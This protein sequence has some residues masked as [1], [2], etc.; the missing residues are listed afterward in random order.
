MIGVEGARSLSEAFK[1]N[2]TLTALNLAGV[3]QDDKSKHGR[4][5]TSND[6][7]ENWISVEGAKALSEALKVN[8]ALTTLDLAGVKHH[9]KAEHGHRTNKNERNSQLYR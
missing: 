2:T 8:T 7:A 4:G 6:K 3:Q 5:T 9:D 1:I